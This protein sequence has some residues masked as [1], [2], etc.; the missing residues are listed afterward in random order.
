MKK[1]LC[2][3]ALIASGPLM[4]SELINV[5]VTAGI[6]ESCEKQT[7]GDR[8]YAATFNFQYREGQVLLAG[9]E[10]GTAKTYVDDEIRVRVTRPDGTK[11]TYTHLYG[12]DGPFPPVDIA[13]LFQPGAN[14]VTVE[15]NDALGGCF[16]SSAIWMLNR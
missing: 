3:M 16:K 1:L 7:D 6:P 8:Y 9:N 15:F 14:K 12:F 13:Y 10:A 5:S 11:R 2:A 4:A